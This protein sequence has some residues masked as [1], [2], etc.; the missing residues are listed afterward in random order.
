MKSNDLSK[1]I[2][3]DQT[4][5]RCVLEGYENTA[6]LTDQKGFAL[7]VN[8]KNQCIA[9]L[10]EG[11]IRNFLVNGG[12]LDSKV[13]KVMNRKFIF[14]TPNE[15]PHQILRY[16]DGRILSLPILDKNFLIKA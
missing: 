7:I 16:F 2:Y 9:T 11:D 5:I 3:S 13:S 10:S 15:T 12:S 14:G 1:I 4:K 6:I 8:K